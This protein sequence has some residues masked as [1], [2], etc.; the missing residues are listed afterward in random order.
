MVASTKLAGSMTVP[1]LILHLRL[2]SS[3]VTLG[4][5]SSIPVDK[6]GPRFSNRVLQRA[7]D[8]ESS[9]HTQTKAKDTAIQLPQTIFE[10]VSA[11]QAFDSSPARGHGSLV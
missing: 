11:A 6:I 8:C 9:A 2:V 3:Q 10:S 4:H 1:S 7:C 5:M